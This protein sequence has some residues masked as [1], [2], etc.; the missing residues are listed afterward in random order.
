MPDV[1][2]AAGAFQESRSQCLAVLAADLCVAALRAARDLPFGMC[3]CDRKEAFDTQWRASMQQKMVSCVEPRF[4]CLADELLRTTS[5]SVV[6]HGR[7]SR[8]FK[9]GTG[10]VEGRRLS[11]LQFCLGQQRLEPEAMASLTGVGVNPPLHALVAFHSTKAALHLD[12][13]IW[14]RFT[15]SSTRCKPP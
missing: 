9:T 12:P 14:M 11:P 6:C 4:W 3:Y 2:E 5:M 1:W 10:V 15:C 13:T 8:W 7:R